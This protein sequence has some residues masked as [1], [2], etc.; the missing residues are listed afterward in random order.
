MWVNMTMYQESLFPSS[1]YWS[2]NS[3]STSENTIRGGETYSG[4]H[5]WISDS[6][7]CRIRSYGY[8]VETVS[9][10][11]VVEVEV[12]WDVFDCGSYVWPVEIS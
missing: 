5:D 2:S 9:V 4:I 1:Q 12:L 8:G 11:R 10:G 7:P 6:H 3:G